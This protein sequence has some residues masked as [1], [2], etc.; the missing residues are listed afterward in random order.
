M[1]LKGGPP[2]PVR[3]LEAALYPSGAQGADAHPV[4]GERSD[5]QSAM[6]PCDKS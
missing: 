5:P 4:R 6:S 2:E 3:G 1:L